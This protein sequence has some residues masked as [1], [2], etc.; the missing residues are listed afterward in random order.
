[1]R[2]QTVFHLDHADPS[3]SLWLIEVEGPTLELAL[4]QNLRQAI[5]AA[6]SAAREYFGADIFTQEELGNQIHII[7]EDGRWFA[8]ED[9]SNDEQPSTFFPTI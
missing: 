2:Y 8:A 5:V 7:D 3:I 6:E 4:K 1:M 9:L